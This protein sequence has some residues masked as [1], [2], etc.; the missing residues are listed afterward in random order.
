MIWTQCEYG[1]DLIII[2]EMGGK[3]KTHK[4]WEERNLSLFLL[5]SW[6]NDKRPRFFIKLIIYALKKNYL[7]VSLFLKQTNIIIGGVVRL[8]YI[9][10][11]ESI[12]NNT[13][14]VNLF[15]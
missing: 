4:D 12:F 10:L 9:D 13:T 2:I 1:I 14:L 5:K 15:L 11:S 7:I 3:A 8:D 6:G